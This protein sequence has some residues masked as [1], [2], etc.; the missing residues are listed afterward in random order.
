MRQ[1][2]VRT[3]CTN[4]SGRNIATA[5]AVTSARMTQKF[6]SSA[7]TTST[8]MFQQPGKPEK[9]LSLVFIRVSAK[10]M[11]LAK[12]MT[13]IATQPVQPS[14]SPDLKSAKAGMNT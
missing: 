14:I 4:F 3:G 1:R 6:G 10:Y 8:T 2:S 13:M 5:R 12:V 9:E 7:K 11:A